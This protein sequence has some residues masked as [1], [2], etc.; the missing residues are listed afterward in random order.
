VAKTSVAQFSVTKCSG[1]GS[2]MK[3]L[4]VEMTAVHGVRI[5]IAAKP[6]FTNSSKTYSN[7]SCNLHLIIQLPTRTRHCM[8]DSRSFICGL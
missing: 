3:Y 8:K 5:Q 6:Q 2:R 4:S 7:K 1:T